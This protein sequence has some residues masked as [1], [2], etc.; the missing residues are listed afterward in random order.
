MIKG[1]C[2]GLD[3]NKLDCSKKNCDCIHLYDGLVKVEDYLDEQWEL[4]QLDQMGNWD[5]DYE[6]G[7]DDDDEDYVKPVSLSFR[8]ATL[9]RFVYTSVTL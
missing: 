2:G 7:D 9:L 4:D 6:E 8:V 1:R 3:L 5:K